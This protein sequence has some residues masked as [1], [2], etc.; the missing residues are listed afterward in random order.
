MIRTCQKTHRLT[1]GTR[2]ACFMQESEAIVTEIAQL[3]SLRELYLEYSCQEP[4]EKNMD[5][6]VYESEAEEK[7][8]P[9]LRGQG[10]IEICCWV[11]K[12][13]EGLRHLTL[14]SSMDQVILKR[15]FPITS[16][17]HF[18]HLQ[19]DDVRLYCHRVLDVELPIF[20]PNLYGTLQLGTG[21]APNELQQ[22]CAAE[23]QHSISGADNCKCISMTFSSILSSTDFTCLAESTDWS[24]IKRS[25]YSHLASELQAIH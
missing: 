1:H 14:D 7:S 17:D 8:R 12:S 3:P 4:E 24:E 10:F 15:W 9:E 18:S 6:T 22:I 25:W 5:Y 16:H 13:Y 21:W 2:D 20:P 23:R 19:V 11:L